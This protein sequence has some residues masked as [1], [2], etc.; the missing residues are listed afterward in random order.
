[1]NA[2][3]RAEWTKAVGACVPGS[4]IKPMLAAGAALDFPGRWEASVCGA[5]LHAAGLRFFGTGDYKIWRKACGR[6][7]A[8]DAAGPG[9]PREGFP[10]LTAGWDLKTGRWT[11]LRLCGSSRGA[12]LEPAQALAW[13]FAPGG[14]APARRLLSPAP[15]KAGAFGEPALDLA[16]EEFSRLSPLASLTVS[17]PGWSLRLARPLRWPMFA[18]CDL[19]AAFTP[20]SSQLALFLLDRS[21]TELSFDGESPWAHCAG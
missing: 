19:S 10:W 11:A 6:T 21:V 16:L 7:F 9:S 15:F 3:E 18:R 13:D 8:L 17:A 2:K 4:A 14:E 1:M 12:A 20:N 5:G